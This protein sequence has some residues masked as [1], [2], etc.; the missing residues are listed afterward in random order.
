MTPFGAGAIMPG[1]LMGDIATGGAVSNAKSVEATNAANFAE[2]QRNRDFQERLSGS[3]YQRA[4]ADM[5]AAGLNPAL[6]Y[7]QGGASTPT[8]AT[9]TATAPR[10]GDIGAGLFNTAKGIATQGAELQQ[11]GSQTKLNEAQTS[12][13]E[14]N[15]EKLGASAKETEKNIEVLEETKKLKK[16]ETKRER[17]LRKMDEA[18]VPAYQKKADIDN[19][20]AVPDSVIKRFWN[21]ISPFGKSN[22]RQQQRRLP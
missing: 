11:V 10:K 14:V 8:G 22:A 9:A 15:T 17:A 16:E 6:A 18:D 1:D 5:R 3:A 7:S 12:Q 21:Y 2:S 4:V 13:A 19:T 20:M